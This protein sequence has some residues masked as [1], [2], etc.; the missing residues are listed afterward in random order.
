AIAALLAIAVVAALVYA[1]PFGTVPGRGLSQVPLNGCQL[2]VWGFGPIGTGSYQ[3]GFLD[4]SAGTF[5][6]ASS[7]ISFP[8]YVQVNELNLFAPAISYDRAAGAF[9][10]VPSSWIAPGGLS[11][12]YLAG[13]DI[14]I[15][16]LPSQ[17]DRV[18]FS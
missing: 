16:Y 2:P 15:R 7:P 12:V 9:L 5:T 1:N 13:S 10:P 4:V 8:R 3:V 17:S 6:P 18:L 14:H 11:Y